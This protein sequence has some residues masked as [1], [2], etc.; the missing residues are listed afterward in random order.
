MRELLYLLLLSLLF[1]TLS[2]NQSGRKES[3]W[4]YFQNRG[5]IFATAYNIKYSYSRSLQEEITVELNRFDNSLNPFNANSI[6][7]KIN[8]N[9][10][11]EPDSFFINLFKKSI[12]ISQL[13]DGYFDITASPLIN[14]WG[15]GYQDIDLITQEVID[16]LRQFVGYE[17]ISIDKYGKVIKS[18]PRMQLN[19]SAIAKGY[20]CD[21]IADLLKSFG[22]T[23]FMIE[24]GGEI[25]AGG[26]N[27]K[28]S[29]WRIGINKPNNNQTLPMMQ[30][31]L[32]TVI[33]LCNK[34]LATSGNYRNFYI[35]DGV[36]YSH[37]IDP[38][39]GYPSKTDILSATVIAE[40]CMTADAFATAFVAMGKDKSVGIAN[41]LPE[42][43][44]YFIYLTEDGS[45]QTTFSKNFEQFFIIE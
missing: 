7:T 45:H 28:G 17:K 39:T 19:A 36:R 35:K 13:S 20:A 12:E 33:S 43:H 41:K 10:A 1:S 5:K 27:E 29:C 14:A 21:V 24:I 30:D 16:S 9:I 44:Y 3:E 4:I 25:T 31:E 8:N 18:D 23:N 34:S 22:V 11:V 2:C 26:V 6:I 42:L 37:T 32:Q 15:F 38:F 40:D